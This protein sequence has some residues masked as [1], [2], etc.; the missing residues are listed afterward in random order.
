MNRRGFIAG[1]A[2]ILAAP[3]I[4]RAASIMPV[5]VPKAAPQLY[6]GRIEHVDIWCRALSAE[7]VAILRRHPHVIEV[8][9]GAGWMVTHDPA[10][11]LSEQQKARAADQLIAERGQGRA[12]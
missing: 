12:A 10:W 2:G 5:S 7:E 4:V 9:T 11:L 3:T 8:A 1:L 6:F